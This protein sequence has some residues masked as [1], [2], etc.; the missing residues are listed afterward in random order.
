[1]RHR[2]LEAFN[3]VMMSGSTVRAAELMGVTQPAVSRLIAELEAAVSFPL[4]DRVRRRLVPTPEG[5]QFYREV[6]Q[7]FR[8]IDRLRA[9]AA[10]IRDFGTG[11]LRVASLA[12]AGAS[13]VPAALRAFR[14]SNPDIRI[15]LHINWSAAIRNGVA[16]GLYDIGVAAEEADR[17]GIGSQLFANYPGVI[18]MPQDHRLVRHDVITPALLR[19]CP[20]VGLAPEDKARHR[21]DT[22]LEDAGVTPHYVIETPSAETV[23]ALVLSGDC[24]GFV[25]PIVT[26]HF[27]GDGLVMKPFAPKVVFKT[28][29]LFPPG[30]QKSRLVKDF[31]G[32]LMAERTEGSFSVSG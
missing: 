5:R 9:A 3:A 29:L 26:K 15:T 32:T 4:F 18:A 6:E 14:V 8:G 20:M 21:F 1:M 10:N 22:V 19:D 11:S 25:N 13:L 31:I 27:K 23:C 7:N 12:A 2:Q 24:V 30:V 17:G 16:D 28:Y